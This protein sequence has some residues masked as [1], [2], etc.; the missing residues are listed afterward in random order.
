MSWRL[1]EKTLNLD[2]EEKPS[3]PRE[4][5]S[6]EKHIKFF[7]RSLDILPSAYASLDTSRLVGPDDILMSTLLIFK[8]I[9]FPS[10]L[11]KKSPYFVA[12][13]VN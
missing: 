4:D 1:M 7:Q 2:G 13:S 11:W 3:K 8:I 12:T 6:R 10:P 5:F 9:F